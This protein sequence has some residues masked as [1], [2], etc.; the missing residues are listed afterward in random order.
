MLERTFARP[1]SEGSQLIILLC[2]KKSKDILDILLSS[3][4]GVDTPD[5]KGRIV[6]HVA[7]EEAT[8]EFIQTLRDGEADLSAI[9]QLGRTAY[10]LAT[11][12]KSYDIMRMLTPI[13]APLGFRDRIGRTALQIAL[14]NGFEDTVEMLLAGGELAHLPRDER[15]WH[16]TLRQAV[17]ISSGCR[18]F[19]QITRTAMA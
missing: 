4:Q 5:A 19:S 18:N 9:D 7:V 3:G 10:H 1:I 16:Y 12:L 15:E 2:A 14:F 8:M 11:E 17:P 13:G 6:I